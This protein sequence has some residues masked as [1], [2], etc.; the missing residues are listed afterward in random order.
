[1]IAAYNRL[2]AEQLPAVVVIG[3]SLDKLKDIRRGNSYMSDTDFVCSR[4]M[5]A[6]EAEDIMVTLRRMKPANFL[7]F[8]VE[9]GALVRNN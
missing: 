9:A 3:I 8:V 7:Y 5:T 1:V 4:P 6:E 2:I